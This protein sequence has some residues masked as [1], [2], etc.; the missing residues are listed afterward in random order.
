MWQKVNSKSGFA[1]FFFAIH[2]E[3]VDLP[4]ESIATVLFD[5]TL[6]YI[7]TPILILIA[8]GFESLL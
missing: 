6:V 3:R 7:A 8:G 4:T 1:T 5:C 2:Q